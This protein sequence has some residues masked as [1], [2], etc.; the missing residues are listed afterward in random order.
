MAWRYQARCDGCGWR[1]LRRAQQRE[2][3]LDKG[4]HYCEAP[5]TLDI[6][7]AEAFDEL[8]EAVVKG[9]HALRHGKNTQGWEAVIAARLYVLQHLPRAGD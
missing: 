8:L 1:G 4:L 9:R 2:A 3:W 7:R 6:D 5:Q